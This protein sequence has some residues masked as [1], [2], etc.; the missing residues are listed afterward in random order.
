MSPRLGGLIRFIQSVYVVPEHRGKGIFISLYN[1]VVEKAKS[2]EITKAVRL[3]VD[4][5]NKEAI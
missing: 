5:T 2:E 1:Q 3:Y 4:H